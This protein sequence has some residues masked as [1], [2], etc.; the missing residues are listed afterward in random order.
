MLKVSLIGTPAQVIAATRTHWQSL[1][2]DTAVLDALEA[3]LSPPSSLRYARVG[4]IELFA[5]TNDSPALVD[6]YAPEA[7][8]SLWQAPLASAAT[9]TV[10]ATRGELT[11]PAMD[12]AAIVRPLTPRYVLAGF[13]LPPEGPGEDYPEPDEWVQPTGAHDAYSL[14]AIVKWGNRWV[15]LIPDNP[16]EPGIS[17]WREVVA[18]GAIPAWVQPTGAQDAYPAGARVTR[19]GRIWL[20]SHGDGNV[21]V[22]GEYGWTDE[23]P[24]E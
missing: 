24:A 5:H 12:G 8:A 11:L 10:Q 18:E 2:R 9:T 17:S 21:W 13:G 16:H 7:E 19:N 23:G 15:S 22:P 20:N 14:G 4:D 6:L 1:G 3:N